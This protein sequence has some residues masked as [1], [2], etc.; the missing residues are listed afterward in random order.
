[1][2]TELQDLL[3]DLELSIVD[4]VERINEAELN[5]LYV[6]VLDLEQRIETLHDALAMV[7]DRIAVD[8]PTS[9]SRTL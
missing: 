8:G 1:M 4:T 9:R 6:A 3:A 7:A 5:L 2:P